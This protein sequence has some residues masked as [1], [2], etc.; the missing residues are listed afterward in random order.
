MGWKKKDRLNSRVGNERLDR[1]GSEILRAAS[2]NEAE[3]ESAVE[4][5]FLFSRISSRIAGEVSRREEKEN[6][7]S[8]LMV[9]SR[10][11]PAMALVAVFCLVLFLASSSGGLVTTGSTEDGLPSALESGIEQVVFAEKQPLSSDDVLTTI[12][13]GEDGEA[14]K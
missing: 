10:A 11:V 12:M 9:F 8:Y 1:L 13:V 6:W 14:A 5:P 3:A 4:S 2:M 7:L